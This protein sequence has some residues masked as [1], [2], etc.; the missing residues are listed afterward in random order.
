MGEAG[1]NQFMWLRNQLVRVAEIFVREENG[2]PT[3]S[4]VRDEQFKLSHKVFDVA[5][6]ANRKICVTLLPHSMDQLKNSYA[7]VRLVARKKE[8]EKFQQIF[9]MKHKHEEFI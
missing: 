8:D 5:D 4:K 7:Q 2:I 3:M 9:F 1:L 6:L